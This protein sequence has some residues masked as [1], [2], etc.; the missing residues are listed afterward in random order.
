MIGAAKYHAEK[1]LDFIRVYYNQKLRVINAR[2]FRVYGRGSKDV[3]SRWIRTALSDRTIELYN[4]E[5]RFDFIFAQDVAEGLLRLAESPA[6]GLVNLRRCV[7]KS[8]QE[9]LEALEKYVPEKNRVNGLGSTQEFEASCA[10]TSKLKELTG[11]TPPTSLNEGIKK[12]AVFVR[13]RAAQ[14]EE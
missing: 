2:I 1:E 6:H 10:G 12:I 7:S 14:R 4:K 3:I 13:N 11:W 8:I 9:V 5:N